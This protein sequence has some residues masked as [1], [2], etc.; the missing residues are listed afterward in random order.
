MRFVHLY[1]SFVHPIITDYLY[2]CHRK[3]VMRMALPCATYFHP[4]P[5]K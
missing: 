4:Q 5:L 2:F 1:F 3:F